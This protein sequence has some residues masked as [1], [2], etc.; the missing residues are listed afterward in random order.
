M[1]FLF[2][3]LALDKPRLHGVGSINETNPEMESV[4]KVDSFFSSKTHYNT[5]RTSSSL[6]NGN[7]L[8][9]GEQLDY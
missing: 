1:I 6:A 3:L 9:I 8:F 2:A 7:A 5:S 4:L